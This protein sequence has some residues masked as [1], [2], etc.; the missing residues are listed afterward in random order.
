MNAEELEQ[1]FNEADLDDQQ[2]LAWALLKERL[3]TAERRFNRLTKG[4]A[5]LLKEV[6]EEFPDACYYTASGG[7]TL[8]IGPTHA[9]DG[10]SRSH[11]TALSASSYLLVSD[12]DY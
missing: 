7:F 12:G 2:Y 6:Q 1:A 10:S 5:Q 9:K 11:N 3:P 8:L 4:L